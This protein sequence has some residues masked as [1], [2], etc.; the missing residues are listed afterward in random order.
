MTKEQYAADIRNWLA[1]L[2]IGAKANAQTM[3]C[4]DC[5]EEDAYRYT[6]STYDHSCVIKDDIITV[7]IHRIEEVTKVAGFE[8]QHRKLEKGDYFYNCFVSEDYF[9]FNGVKFVDYTIKEKIN[10]RK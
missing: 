4:A 8:L 10:E 6:A 7:A 9:M 5:K 3:L 1:D 2:A